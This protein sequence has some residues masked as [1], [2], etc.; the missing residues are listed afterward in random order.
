[1]FAASQTVFFDL[2]GPFSRCFVLLALLAFAPVVKW[3]IF[4]AACSAVP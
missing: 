3:A 4:S 1:M 2:D